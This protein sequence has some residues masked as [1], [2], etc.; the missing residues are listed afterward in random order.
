MVTVVKTPTGHKIIDQAIEATITEDYVGDA[1]V[2]FAYHGL[3][4]GDYVY[5]T[6]DIDEY[7]GF[8]YVTA[9]DVNIFKI[10]EYEDADFVEYYQDADIEYYQTQEHVWNSIF[11]PIVYKI[12]NNRWPINTVDEARTISS[13]IDDN[14]FTEVT[15]S[16][17]L[18][19]DAAALEFVIISGASDE[20]LNGVFQIVEAISTTQYTISLP[21]DADNSFS[22]ATIQYYYNNYQVKVKV[23]AGLPSTHPW[24]PKKPYTEV[25]ELSFTPDDNNLVMFSVADYIKGK[26][27]IKNNTLIYSYPLNLDAFTGFYI[28]TA[29]TYDT[30]DGYTLETTGEVYN[31]DTFEGYAIT[32]KLP[33]KNVYSGD[34]ADYIYTSGSPALWLTMMDRLLAIE[35]KY[36]DISFIKNSVGDF[37]VT[38]DKYVSDYLTTTETIA[39]TDQGIG[40]Y[41]IPITPDATYD[42]FCIS[43]A[44]DQYTE[45]V[46]VPPASEDLSAYSQVSAGGGID[47]PWTIGTTL[48]VQ[49]DPGP[50]YSYSAGRAMAVLLGE[51]VKVNYDIDIIFDNASPPP[52]H[53]T[54]RFYLSDALADFDDYVELL[55]VVD[56]VGSGTVHLTGQLSVS[57]TANR[58]FFK[59]LATKGGGGGTLEVI[60]NSISFGDS[61]TEEVVVPV[62]TVTEEICIDLIETCEALDGFVSDYIRLLEDGDYRLLE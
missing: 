4:D 5:I 61:T 28:A 12:T 21:Y 55:Y 15:L 44:T 9:V 10:S 33:F 39:Y 26:V 2:T 1:V 40:V 27:A 18:K 54:V 48:T 14:G 31:D 38:I 47:S 36:F 8:W 46:T 49:I 3:A 53:E 11:L 23:Y 7:N 52:V 32:G 42:S 25:A 24:E 58:A 43:V 16:G 20:N 6:S 13:F 37:T 29:E 41:R 35:D 62:A 51:T 59:I 60:I 30:S 19:S 57:A 50:V 34:Y 22:G 17:V 56:I 45:T